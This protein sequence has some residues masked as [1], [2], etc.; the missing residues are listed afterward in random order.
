[1]ALLYVSSLVY[2]YNCLCYVLAISR[3]STLYPHYIHTPYSISSTASTLYQNYIHTPHFTPSTAST[4]YQYYIYTPHSTPSTVFT[5]YRDY[6]HTSSTLHLLSLYFTS[7]LHPLSSHSLSGFHPHSIHT[8]FTFH[9][10][11]YSTRLHTTFHSQLVPLINWYSKQKDKWDKW[12]KHL[13]KKGRGP[14][15]SLLLAS[16]FVIILFS[17]YILYR[18]ICFSMIPFTYCVFVRHSPLPT[19]SFLFYT[20]SVLCYITSFLWRFSPTIF[21][22]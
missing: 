14:Y 8:P 19:S 18:V 12:A 10:T 9:S 13:S 6:I 1:M 17:Q 7:T 15:Y 21:F 16:S 2:K 22:F 20:V 11:P 5:L 3:R 4:L